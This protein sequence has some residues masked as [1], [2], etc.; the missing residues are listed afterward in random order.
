MLKDIAL[1]SVALV[2][3]GDKGMNSNDSAELYLHVKLYIE[4]IV[5][6]NHIIIP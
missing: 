6:E 5:V 3:F 1:N 4:V 2:V